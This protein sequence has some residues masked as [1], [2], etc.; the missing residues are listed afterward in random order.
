[1]KTALKSRNCLLGNNCLILLLQ[2]TMR[3]KDKMRTDAFEAR[4]RKALDDKTIKS[5]EDFSDPQKFKKIVAYPSQSE[6][7]NH[8]RADPNFHNQMKVRC[9]TNKRSNAY[10]YLVQGKGFQIA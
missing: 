2:K 10:A 9:L 5:W 1:M 8:S 3:G 7:P 4:L 6:N